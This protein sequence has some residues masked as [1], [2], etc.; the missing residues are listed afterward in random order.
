MTEEKII[1][2]EQLLSTGL[3]CGDLVLTPKRLYFVYNAGFF[4]KKIKNLFDIPIENIINVEATKN[5]LTTEFILK[6]RFR[7]G[8]KEIETKCTKAGWNMWKGRAAFKIEANLFNEW[9]RAIEEARTGKYNKQDS[10]NGLNEL[11]KLAELKEK[12]II[13]DIEFKK[14]KKKILAL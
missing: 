6:I 8:E 11:E 4:K 2:K 12:G 14:K 3:T 7:D 13:T 5:H 9:V 1:K 10:L